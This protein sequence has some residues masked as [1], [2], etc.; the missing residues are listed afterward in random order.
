MPVHLR[1]MSV[2]S[3]TRRNLSSKLCT[4]NKIYLHDLITTCR[5][6]NSDNSNN[7]SSIYSRNTK[8][9]LSSPIISSRPLSSSSLLQRPLPLLS[10]LSNQSFFPS[11]IHNAKDIRVRFKS[12]KT[13]KNKKN[14]EKRMN[15][16]GKKE[17]KN[18]DNAQRDE[19]LKFQSSG[20]IG[21]SDG[22]IDGGTNTSSTSLL[23]S[24]VEEVGSPKP[25][26]FWNDKGK[27]DD[28]ITK[29]RNAFH[30]NPNIPKHF[31]SYH[32]KYDKDES[33]K[34]QTVG[35]EQGGGEYPS[36]RYSDT[37][38]TRLLTEAYEGIPKR[39]GK[40]GSRNLKRQKWR[41]WR[42]RKYAALKK[43]E[44]IVEHTNRMIKR[45]LVAKQCKE[46]RTVAAQVRLEEETY[47][48]G[49]LKKVAEVN[50]M[51]AELKME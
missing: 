1:I 33:S 51:F 21:V 8:E 30:D 47:R 35:E 23:S 5:N 43:S 12:G 15:K 6:Y 20:M 10:L 37:D 2:A 39:A 31:Y 32:H 50:G 26:S 29:Q 45:S 27:G 3:M 44:R 16:K 13:S 38:T 7:H 19:W 18:E 49:V 24:T 9:Y 14:A 48:Q 4:N 11:T 46:V 28:N 25:D 17:T 40:R 42:I 41:W 34:E 36:L 22:N